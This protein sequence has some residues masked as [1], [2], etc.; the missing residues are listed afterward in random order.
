MLVKF[1][2]ASINNELLILKSP[3]QIIYGCSDKFCP[4]KLKITLVNLKITQVKFNVKSYP[5]EFFRVIS[6]TTKVFAKLKQTARN[7]KID[8]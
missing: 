3:F 7:S 8:V 5:E 2:M 6:N 4:N 1:A